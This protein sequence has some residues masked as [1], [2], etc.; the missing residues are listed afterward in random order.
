MMLRQTRSMVHGECRLLV[1]LLLAEL[2]GG[3]DT[4]M[5]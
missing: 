2:Q 4:S 3:E 5:H 1:K